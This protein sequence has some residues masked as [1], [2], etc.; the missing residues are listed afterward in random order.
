MKS[1]IRLVVQAVFI[2]GQIHL[3]GNIL[4]SSREIFFV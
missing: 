1:L 4:R 3:L 2:Q